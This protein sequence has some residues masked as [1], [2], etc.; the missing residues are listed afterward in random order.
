M[1]RAACWLRDWVWAIQLPKHLCQLTEA[2]ALRWERTQ[3][4]RSYPTRPQ[5]R[6]MGAR[7]RG[8]G[9]NSY[10]PNSPAPHPLGPKGGLTA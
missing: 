9:T 6:R 3:R 10:P 5:E 4:S 7:E 2:C 1:L 8:L